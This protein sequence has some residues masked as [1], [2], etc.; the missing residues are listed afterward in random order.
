MRGSKPTAPGPEQPRAVLLRRLEETLDRPATDAERALMLWLCPP[1]AE[2]RRLPASRHLLAAPWADIDRAPGAEVG[3]LK[4][5]GG[6]A[7]AVAVDS[8]VYVDP[9]EH[10]DLREGVAATLA[11]LVAVGVRPLALHAVIHCGLPEKAAARE[12]L[13]SS[14]HALS[15][16]ARRQ[17][18]GVLGAKPL[19]DPEYGDTLLVDSVAIGWREAEPAVAGRTPV[20]GDRL[21]AVA[22][23]ELDRV[24]ADLASE[25]ISFLALPTSSDVPLRAVVAAVGNLGLDLAPGEHDAAHPEKALE[26]ARPDPTRSI[27]LIV[28]A[29]AVDR[30]GHIAAVHGAM[31][32]ELGRIRAD[33][34]LTVGQ[35][36]ASAVD[37]PAAAVREPLAIPGERSEP[38]DSGPGRDL[39][40][41]DLP[42]PE[43][44]DDAFRR[45]LRAPNLAS[46]QALYQ[47]FDSWMG[48]ATVLHPGSGGGVAALRTPSA[49]RIVAVATSGNPRFTALDPYVGFCIAV[50]EGVRR[51]ATAGARPRALVGGTS[52]GAIH[53]PEVRQRAEQGLAGL[54]DA[55]LAFSLPCLALTTSPA[56][57]DEHP[58]MPVTPGLAFLGSLERAPLTPWFKEEGDVVILLGRSREEVAGS[59]FA[60]YLHGEVDGNP[61]WVDFESERAV[62]GVLETGVERGILHSARNV[63]AGGLALAIVNSCCSRP[64]G[65]PALGARISIDEGMRPDAWLFAE[66]Q[67]RVVV[68]VSREHVA[69]LRD[70]ADEAEL[71]FAQVGEVGGGVL[72]FGELVGLTLDE[73]LDIWNGALAERL[74]GI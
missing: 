43:D 19:F 29:D 68:S 62:R 7:V 9:A 12:G 55:A 37:L 41:E 4:L 59:E 18:I 10:P 36:G 56:G 2:L 39:R 26:R 42:E 67:G 72:E 44:Y 22:G 61:P 5:E 38:D 50:C 33:P 74:G 47:R 57:P 27:L 69:G 20:A 71:P 58:A 49:G 40:L 24:R 6:G 15:E 8:R 14:L 13:V 66:S 23:R 45:V 3:F 52:F 34:R 46:R 60:A 64:A 16:Y 65:V 32:A 70:L 25:R 53:D 1:A 35:G 30:V 48:G 11:K 73:L 21:V 31:A 51:L 63:D 54:R 28:A 17:G